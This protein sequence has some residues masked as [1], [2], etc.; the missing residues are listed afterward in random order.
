MRFLRQLLEGLDWLLD[1]VPSYEHG[2]W[3]RFGGW[4][5]R[6]HM[7]NI[8]WNDKDMTKEHT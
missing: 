5:C 7:S 6:M 1:S 4:G 3:Y 8:W 2:Q